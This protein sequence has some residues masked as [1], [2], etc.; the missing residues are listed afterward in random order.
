MI[1]GYFDIK[2]DMQ[3]SCFC[4]GCLVGK[5]ANEQSLDPRYC[6]S[7]YEILLKE[8]ELLDGR[9]R[10]AWIPKDSQAT[11]RTLQKPS[12]KPVEGR[13]KCPKA[14][15][16]PQ[17]GSAPGTV[18]FPIEQVRLWHDEGLSVRVITKR[19]NEQGIMV[20]RST[21]HRAIMKDS[22]TVLSGF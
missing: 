11:T 2:R 12:L 21:V 22:Q 5:T 7:C 6:Q 10:P 15:P 1:S 14:V 3:F 4:E 8:A 13:Q 20:G 19:L 9:R 17:I 18:P 16:A